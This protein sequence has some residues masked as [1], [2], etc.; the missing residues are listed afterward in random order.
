MLTLILTETLTLALRPTVGT[1]GMSAKH[2]ENPE[3]N[4]E[5]GSNDVILCHMFQLDLLIYF[6]VVLISS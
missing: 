5:E 1:V 2:R 4:T 3:Q 6:F